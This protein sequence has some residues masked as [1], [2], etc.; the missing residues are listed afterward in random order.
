[1][2][3]KTRVLFLITRTEP[4]KK[5]ESILFLKK[6][7]HNLKFAPTIT[8]C[9]DILSKRLFAKKM[10][11]RLLVLTTRLHIS[12]LFLSFVILCQILFSETTTHASPISILFVSLSS[13]HL[14]ESVCLPH[15]VTKYCMCDLLGSG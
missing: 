6:T 3:C 10:N 12:S 14:L 4:N 9:L 7:T 11:T 5:I 8:Y 2:P 15:R 13:Q 1:M